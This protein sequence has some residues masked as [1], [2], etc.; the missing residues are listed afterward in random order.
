ML[1]GTTSPTGCHDPPHHEIYH[2]VTGPLHRPTAESLHHCITI[3]SLKKKKKLDKQRDHLHHTHP[4]YHHHHL[5]NNRFTQYYG[6]DK[7]VPIPSQIAC[8]LQLQI[9][10]TSLRG[11]GRVARAWG[12]FP[13]FPL[14]LEWD[15]Y[16]TRDRPPHSS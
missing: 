2:H 16:V 1:V 11:G 10:I 5:A 3:S 6:K 15:E 13:K 14:V 4:Y 7:I 8:K 12:L 9:N